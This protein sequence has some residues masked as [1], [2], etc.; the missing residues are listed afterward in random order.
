MHEQ[1]VPMVCFPHAGAG[2]L[3]YGRW[4]AAFTTSVEL[5]VAQYPQREQKLAV[6][7]PGSVRELAA[8]LVEELRPVFSRPYVIWG[9]S[10]GS[11][12]GYEVAK[13]AQ[14]RF[15]P[16]LVFF[17]SGASSPSVSRFTRADDLAT[18]ESMKDV[19]RSYGG[20][21]E[22][23]LADPD[24]MKWFAPAIRADLR[25]LSTYQDTEF[26]RLR[27]PLVLLE[28]RSDKVQIEQ[29]PWYAEGPVEV[30]E[31][32][33]GHFFIDEHRQTIA[34][35]IESRINLAWQRRPQTV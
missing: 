35:L 24:F 13:I 27:C 1:K 9:H 18:D 7:M 34:A 4:R 28:G 31:F 10:M 33:G 21:S 22:A 8:D 15:G 2:R 32:D 25:L 26:E 11:V 5:T 16:P 19:L 3:Y 12:V 20:I 17:S 30:H 23:S 14:E 6:P 29:W